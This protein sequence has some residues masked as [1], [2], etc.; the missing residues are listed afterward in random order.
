MY[1][2][3][4]NIGPYDILYLVIYVILTNLRENGNVF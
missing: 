4:I 2:L 3:W 1:R